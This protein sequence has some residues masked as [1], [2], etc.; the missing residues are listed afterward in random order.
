MAIVERRRILSSHSAFTV[1]FSDSTSAV[2]AL[3]SSAIRCTLAS[4]AATI[5]GGAS[6]PP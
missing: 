6:P 4:M 3:S 5:A 1:A 2:R